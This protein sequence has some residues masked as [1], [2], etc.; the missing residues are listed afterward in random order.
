MIDSPSVE[1]SLRSGRPNACNLCHLDRSLSWTGRYLQEWYKIPTGSMT[2]DEAS[3]SAAVLGLL[4]G[5]AGERAIVA[6]HMGWAPALRASGTDWE[7]PY[8]AQLLDDRY[9]AVRYLAH[10]SLL[11]LEGYRGFQFDNVGPAADRGARWPE[12]LLKPDGNPMRGEI[13]RLLL[14]RDDHPVVLLE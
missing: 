13:E 1:N 7:A 2:A 6:W 3:I 14:E 8:L 11:R 12:I 5:D 4:K 10:R 9:A